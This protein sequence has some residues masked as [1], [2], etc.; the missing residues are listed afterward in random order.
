MMCKK[1]AFIILLLVYANLSKAQTGNSD[2]ICWSRNY[3]LKWSDFQGKQP[4]SDSGRF[5]A[6]CSASIRAKGFM[7][8]DLPNFRITNC[9]MKKVS[10]TTDTV[11]LKLLEH[12]QLHF[13]IA[14]L[15]ARKMRKAIESLRKKKLKTYNSYTP[16]IQ[17]LLE[18]REAADD[19][20]D[21]EC[22]HGTFYDQQKEW[23]VKVTKEL[24]ELKKYASDRQ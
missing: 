20:Y 4:A 14:D 3:K 18:E 6:G 16:T 1:S 7:D 13:D 8:K 23:M 9:F 11:S 19:E 22:V 5:K 2:S 24:D 15:Y 17:K 21:K 10:W 12:E